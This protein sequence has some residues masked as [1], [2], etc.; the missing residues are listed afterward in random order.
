MLRKPKLKDPYLGQQCPPPAVRTMMPQG[1]HDSPEVTQP[2]EPELGP[3][4][5]RLSSPLT[6]FWIETYFPCSL[7]FVTFS[8][9]TQS[10]VSLP[11]WPAAADFNFQ[12]SN[13]NNQSIR[14]HPSRRTHSF[15]ASWLRG[16]GGA[17]RLSSAF[18]GRG[19]RI[20]ARRSQEGHCGITLHPM[21]MRQELPSA[22][23]NS[24]TSCPKN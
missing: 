3:L 10:H 23:V 1:V 6:P 14:M 2:V 21:L 12:A 16:E 17:S 7:Y 18:L 20:P 11:C 9:P 4:G 22:H 24:R 19:Q 13:L 15:P 8:S 5:S